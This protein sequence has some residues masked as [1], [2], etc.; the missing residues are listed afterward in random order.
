LSRGKA[1]ARPWEMSSWAELLKE[2]VK[3]RLRA[4]Q[5]ALARGK[6]WD[7]L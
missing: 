4:Q 5:W 3:E 1:K 7:P 6:E 2:K